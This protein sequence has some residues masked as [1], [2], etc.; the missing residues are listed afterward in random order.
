MVA[1]SGSVSVRSSGNP[2]AHSEI[3]GLTI[4]EGVVVHTGAMSFAIHPGTHI[5][6]TVGKIK[7]TL[8]VYLIVLETAFEAIAVDE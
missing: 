5:T 8:A 1:V 4:A 2:P 3:H 6:V 7:C